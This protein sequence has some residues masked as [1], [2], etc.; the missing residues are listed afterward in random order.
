VIVSALLLAWRRRPIELLVLVV[1]MLLIYAAVHIT[2]GAVDRPRPPQ[3]LT[4]SVGSA[5]PSGHAAYST[6]YVAMAIIAARV[7]PGLVSRAALVIVAVVASA[8]IG[9]SRMFLGVHW[10][11]DVAGGW[12]LGAAIFGAVGVVGL[13]VGYF[14]NNGARVAAPAS[15]QRAPSTREP[16]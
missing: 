5:Y 8:A 10:W 14:R 16:V 9:G 2:K 1:S 12:G 3:P 7:L 13:V 11:S 15:S 4:G 6:A